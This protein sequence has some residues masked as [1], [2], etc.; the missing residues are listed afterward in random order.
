MTEWTLP[1]RARALAPALRSRAEETERLGRLP[2][3]T[4]VDLRD[5]GLLRALQPRRF[6]GDE[7]PLSIFFEAQIEVAKACGSTGWVLGVL[8]IHNWML[9]MY[10]AGAA[11]R[12]GRRRGRA[13]APTTR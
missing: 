8:G 12:L 9:A 6:G 7:L 3:A 13:S 2:D 11:R 1:E 4:I 5:A 10:G